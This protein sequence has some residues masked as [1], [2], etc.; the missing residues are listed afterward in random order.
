MSP[1]LSQL[2]SID[3]NIVLHI[4]GD[5]A[6]TRSDIGPAFT[7]ANIT[8][9]YDNGAC[10]GVQPIRAT[11]NG[12][13][14]LATSPTI[15]TNSTIFPTTLTWLARYRTTSTT[16][17]ILRFTSTRT[18]G[19]VLNGYDFGVNPSTGILEIAVLAGG[20]VAGTTLINF[21]RTAT[22]IASGAWHTVGFS[23]TVS[24]NTV[25]R[26]WYDGAQLGAT[27]S[28]TGLM[29]YGNTTARKLIGNFDSGAT[30]RYLPGD[31]AYVTKW[32]AELTADQMTAA[33]LTMSIG[34]SRRAA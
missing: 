24:S 15:A 34:P 30:A 1:L 33:H 27:G 32:S 28:M 9:A 25:A 17:Q 18:G 6:C 12:S 5:G 22:G 13:S 16:N 29:G 23:V 14:S 3:P 11:F 26:I 4:P 31:L 20:A 2:L 7:Q 19:S 21:N 10:G 8:N